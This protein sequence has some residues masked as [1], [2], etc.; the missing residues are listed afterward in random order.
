MAGRLLED[1]DLRVV[2]A[3]AEDDVFALLAQLELL[4]RTQALLVDADAGSLSRRAR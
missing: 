1:D 2:G 3:Q 4:V